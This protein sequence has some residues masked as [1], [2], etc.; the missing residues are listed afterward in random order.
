[1]VPLSFRSSVGLPLVSLFRQD[2]LA[3]LAK[4]WKNLAVLDYS[5]FLYFG[6]C[7]RLEGKKTREEGQHGKTGLQRN[8]LS[9]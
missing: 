3:I 1:M 8:L 4:K 6:F 7:G 9:L 2:R 5:C